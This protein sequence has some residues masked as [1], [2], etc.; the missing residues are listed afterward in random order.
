MT[1]DEQYEFFLKNHYCLFPSALSPDEVVSI[2][3]AID[4]SLARDGWGGPGPR[5]TFVQPLNTTTDFDILPRHRSFFPLASRIF[6]GDIAL[7]E[8]AIM[9]RPGNQE[10]PTKPTGWHQDFGICEHDPLGITALSAVM[11]LTDIDKTTARYCLLPNSQRGDKPPQ[12][13]AEGSQDV[14]GEVEVVGPAGTIVLVNAGIYHTG[15]PGTGPRERRTIHTY[16]QR[17]CFPSVSNHTILPR[18]LWDVEDP[19]QRRFYSHFNDVT[20]AALEAEAAKK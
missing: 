6:D 9:T 3:A 2:N 15:K 11:C 7:I 20:R 8:F 5:A 10:A 12:P 16:M 4:R 1:L 17:T 19:A 13:V 14:V 18:R